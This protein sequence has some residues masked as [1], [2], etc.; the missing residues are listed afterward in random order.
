VCGVAALGLS[1]I[2]S[3]GGTG[4]SSASNDLVIKAEGSG[5]GLH[6]VATGTDIASG[7]ILKIRNHTNEPHT[8][9][10]VKPHRLPHGA[11]A[12]KRCFLHGHICRAIVGWHGAHGQINPVDVGRKGW[13]KEGNLRYKGDSAFFTPAKNPKAAKVSAAPGTTLHY[14]CAFHPW[15]H[16]RIH[17]D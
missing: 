10:L 13:D 12:Q 16:G 3:A 8:L 14:I 11:K 7:G 1:G 4:K 6:Y 9:S 17:V 15:M 5:R 2:A